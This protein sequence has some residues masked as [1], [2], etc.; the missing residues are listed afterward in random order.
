[1]KFG[2]KKSSLTSDHTSIITRVFRVSW[3]SKL[4]KKEVDGENDSTKKQQRC[5][6]DFATPNSSLAS[7]WKQGR[8]YSMDDDDD[9]YWRISFG[10]ERIEGRRSTGG[11]KINPVWYDHEDEFQCRKRDECRNFNDMVMD[12]KRMKE[13]QRI[14]RESGGFGIRSKAVND[15]RKQRMRRKQSDEVVSKSL[16]KDVF[17]IESD[18]LVRL[19]DEFWNLDVSNSRDQHKISP[20]FC[21]S[22][23]NEDDVFDSNKGNEMKIKTESRSL[24]RESRSRKA[25]QMS[26]VKTYS[27][28]AECKIRAIEEMKKAK[29]KLKKMNEMK[30]QVME[31]DAV[32]GSFAVAKSSFNPERDFRDSMVEMIRERG[33]RR[34]EELEELLACYLTLNGDE[35]HGVII[36]VFREV[37]FKL[38]GACLDPQIQNSHVFYN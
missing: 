2:R 4:K 18:D 30:E 31:C 34:P 28:R 13:K 10:E 36:K 3:L 16:E 24:N 37:W 6:L 23:V 11:I 20:N 26:R 12:V 1:M 19:R 35:Y 25:K 21:R 5:K 33:I 14:V 27:P 32:F 7:G 22:S 17:A 9:A 15:R 29:M 8:F 38:N